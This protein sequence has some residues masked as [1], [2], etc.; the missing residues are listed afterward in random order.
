MK[1]A[2]AVESVVVVLAVL[3]LAAYAMAPDTGAVSQEQ[4]A[5][6][7]TCPMHPEVRATWAGKCPTCGMNLV[8][9]K[10]EAPRTV[11]SGC[12]CCMWAGPPT[13]GAPGESRTPEAMMK[14]MGMS[15]AMMMR[16][17][18]MMGMTIDASEPVALLSLKDDLGLAAEQI[19]RLEAIAEKARRDAGAVLTDEQKAKI[20]T[21][22]A[23]PRSMREMCREMMQM[24]LGDQAAQHPMMM[25]P[26]MQMMHGGSSPEGSSAR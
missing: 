9:P 18:M 25:C 19:T 14:A 20:G 17:R 3:L 1:C 6:W 22:A 11:W 21:F 12:P 15:P 5:A 13:Q 16:C 10:A 8:I 23:T 4:T 26:M 2:R 24:M 7:Y